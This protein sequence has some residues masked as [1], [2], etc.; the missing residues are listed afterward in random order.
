MSRAVAGPATTNDEAG[1]VAGSRTLCERLWH[2]QIADDR[3]R[4]EGG[5][6]SR[7][8]TANGVEDR[9]QPELSNEGPPPDEGLEPPPPDDP[10]LDGAPPA[11][12]RD[13]S[14]AGAA[15]AAGAGWDALDGAGDSCVPDASG[16]GTTALTTCAGGAAAR[17][18]ADRFR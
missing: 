14:G 5:D 12:E 1:V 10:P 18:G 16:R 15:A 11:G 13:G 9:R 8:P 6:H 7:G 17:M 2:G 3:N 4:D